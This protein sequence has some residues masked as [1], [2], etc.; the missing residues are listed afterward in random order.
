MPGGGIKLGTN[1]NAS[2]AS[3]TFAGTEGYRLMLDTNATLFTEPE[4]QNPGAPLTQNPAGGG[5]LETFFSPGFQ[6]FTDTI[7]T[8]QDERFQSIRQVR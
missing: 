5:R 6:M 7:D 8:T 3:S 2:M 1:T 4:P